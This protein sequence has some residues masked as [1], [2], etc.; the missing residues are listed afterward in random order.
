MM[1]EVIDKASNWV[2]NVDLEESLQL[3]NPQTGVIFDLKKYFPNGVSLE[4]HDIIGVIF[5]E[6]GG[7]AIC[8]KKKENRTINDL[9]KNRRM[10]K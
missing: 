6:D 1:I 4:T 10:K 5:Y 7:A 2:G 3:A 8:F 9:I